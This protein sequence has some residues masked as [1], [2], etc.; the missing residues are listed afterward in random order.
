MSC[1]KCAEEVTLPGS[2]DFAVKPCRD[3]LPAVDYTVSDLQKLVY[4]CAVSHGWHDAPANL[5]EKLALIHSEVSEALE[6][7]RNHARPDD[8]RFVQGK[9]EGFAVELADIVIRVLDLAESLRIDLAPVIVR[10]HAYNL[11]RPHK[12]GGKKF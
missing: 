10:K 8:I 2:P 6:E 3:V 11:G 4:A 9:P 5:P 7:L 1:K 12:H